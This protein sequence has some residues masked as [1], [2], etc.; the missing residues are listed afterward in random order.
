[1]AD[2]PESDDES[3]VAEKGNTYP[4]HKSNVSDALSMRGFHNGGCLFILI[5]GILALL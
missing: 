3:Y 4:I 1:M 5:A 2:W